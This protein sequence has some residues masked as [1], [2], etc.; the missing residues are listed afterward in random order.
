[1]E[2]VWVIYETT[3]VWLFPHFQG[4]DVLSIG[5]VLPIQPS[6]LPAEMQTRGFAV[7]PLDGADYMQPDTER[8]VLQSHISCLGT[9]DLGYRAN[10]LRGEPLPVAGC[11]GIQA[12]PIPPKTNCGCSTRGQEQF[13]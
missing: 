7:N 13:T 4:G 8:L 5:R 1:M 11:R 12:C 2:G 3:T 6:M 9:F 10:S